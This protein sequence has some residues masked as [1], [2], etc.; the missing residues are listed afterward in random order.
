VDL[1]PSLFS[2]GT[3]ID[4]RRHIQGGRRKLEWSDSEYIV[5]G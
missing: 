2:S 1:E 5:K 3:S 4:G